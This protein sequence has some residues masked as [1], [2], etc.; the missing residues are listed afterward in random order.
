MYKLI[1]ETEFDSAHFLK[2]YPGKCA[3]I[4]GHR[5]RI[6][7][8]IAAENLQNTGPERG[9][10]VDFSTLKKAIKGLADSL[11]HQLIYEE[12]ALKPVTVAAL[13]EEGFALLALPF[14]PTAENIAKYLYDEM[15]AQGFPVSCLTVY[16]TPNNAAAYTGESQGA[17]L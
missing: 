9:M 11:D 10:L 14:T 8:E 15:T 7:C 13:E 6:V 17:K 1:T 2:G 16:E 12:G 3:N 5:W 4:H